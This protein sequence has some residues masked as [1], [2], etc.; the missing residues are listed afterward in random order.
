MESAA[1]P[2]FEMGVILMLIPHNNDVNNKISS[3]TN[4]NNIHEHDV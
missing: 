4:F 2:V 3:N 1:G